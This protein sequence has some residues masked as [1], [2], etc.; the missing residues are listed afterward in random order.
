MIYLCLYS[1]KIFKSEFSVHN[2]HLILCAHV[3]KSKWIFCVK[4]KQV[5][6]VWVLEILD[7]ETKL[8]YKFKFNALT[9]LNIILNI[10]FIYL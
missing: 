9:I 3:E 8:I 10:H 1:K 2:I 4:K 6:D 7:V 5:L